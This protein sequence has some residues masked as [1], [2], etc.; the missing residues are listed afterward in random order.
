MLEELCNSEISS[1]NVSEGV[2]NMIDQQLESNEGIDE[3]DKKMDKW[4]TLKVWFV[5][6]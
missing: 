3:W 6:Q 4:K 2:I 5:C 1:P